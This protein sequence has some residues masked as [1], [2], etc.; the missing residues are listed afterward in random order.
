M[1]IKK[2]ISRYRRDF[3]AIFECESCGN[4]R[5]LEGY[6][7]EFFHNSI[8]PSM[9]CDSCGEKSPPSYTPVATKYHDSQIL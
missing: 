1:R 4:E 7:D 2:I 6:D 5:E 3:T 8:I 9:A